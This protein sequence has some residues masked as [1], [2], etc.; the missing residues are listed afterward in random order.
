M[1][2]ENFRKWSDEVP[3]YQGLVPRTWP[4]HWSDEIQK[5]LDQIGDDSYKGDFQAHSVPVLALRFW[6]PYRPRFMKIVAWLREI[7][8]LER[9]SVHQYLAG[10]GDIGIPWIKPDVLEYRCVGGTS[11]YYILFR[12]LLLLKHVRF[13]TMMEYGSFAKELSCSYH[14]PPIL[15]WSSF[16][17]GTSFRQFSLL[18]DSDYSDYQLA[19]DLWWVGNIKSTSQILEREWYQCQILWKLIAKKGRENVQN[20]YLIKKN[21]RKKYRKKYD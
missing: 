3:N 11:D 13:L 18:I 15:I 8:G 10:V 9:G 19:G 16:N 1:D 20:A 7:L 17:Q 4:T 12:L 2:Y 21:A 14:E 6:W 5:I